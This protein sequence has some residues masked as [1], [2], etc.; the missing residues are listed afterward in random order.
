VTNFAMPGTDIPGFQRKAV[1]I[2]L[3]GIYDLRSHKDEVVAPVLRYWKVWDLE[4]LDGEGEAARMEL[5]AYMTELEK[6][7]SRF[8]DKRE[9]MKKRM[10]VA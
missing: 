5:D 9:M 1:E 2:A 4:G 6:Q 8:E 10:G 3:A 7:A